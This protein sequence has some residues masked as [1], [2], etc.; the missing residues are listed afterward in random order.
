[1]SCYGVGTPTLWIR[2][3]V[4]GFYSRHGPLLVTQSTLVVRGAV[5][6]APPCY[7]P[8]AQGTAPPPAVT[9]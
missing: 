8:S 7:G 1:M 3:A 5:L 6:N 2:I 4:C 9:S